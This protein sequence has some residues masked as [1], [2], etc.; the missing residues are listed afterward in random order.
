VV[1]I[2]K[3]I[4]R[5]FIGRAHTCA[6][7]VQHFT[8]LMDPEPSLDLDLYLRALDFYKTPAA[9]TSS[10]LMAKNSNDRAKSAFNKIL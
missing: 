1:V 7:A 3:S 2:S 5:T 8:F 6:P 9:T 4:G 10:Q